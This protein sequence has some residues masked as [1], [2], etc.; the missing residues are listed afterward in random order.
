MAYFPCGIKHSEQCTWISHQYIMELG[1]L[2]IL[3]SL[4]FVNVFFC[5]AGIFLNS[6]VIISLWRS[7]Q[8]RRKTCYFMILVLSCFDL[9][10]VIVGHPATI[11]SSFAWA[12]NSSVHWTNEDGNKYDTNE[13]AGFIRNFAQGFA[14]YALTVMTVDRYLAITRPVFHKTS[15]TKQR[16]MAFLVIMLLLFI[17]FGVVRS[18]KNFQAA[19]YVSVL[20]LILFIP[21][22]LLAFMNFMMFSIAVKTRQN[23]EAS[24]S[25]GRLKLLKKNSTCLLTVACFFVCVTPMIMYAALRAI[26]SPLLDEDLLL[27]I[28]LYVN[29]GLTMNSSLNCL[30]FFWKNRILRAEGKKLVSCSR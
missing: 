23:R 18:I 3:I 8:L 4:C 13:L 16:L 22:L 29:T 20:V 7:F 6:V 24:E 27:L 26:S 30:I 5:L 9:V 10:A 14:L 21:L 15:V 25:K 11:S 19:Y 2:I 12:K 28:R 1:R 17:A